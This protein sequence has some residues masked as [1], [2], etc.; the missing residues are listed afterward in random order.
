MSL[1]SINI[2][3]PGGDPDGIWVA[4]NCISTPQAI[5]FC[6][7]QNAVGPQHFPELA[8]RSIYMVLRFDEPQ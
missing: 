2:F 6:K 7:L 4:Q 1:R 5:A 8:W 3:L